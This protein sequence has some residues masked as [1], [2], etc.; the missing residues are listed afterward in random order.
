MDS[1]RFRAR[2]CMNMMGSQEGY[3]SGALISTVENGI[4]TVF[5]AVLITCVF[6]ETLS[7]WEDLD[8]DRFRLKIE[9]FGLETPRFRTFR[10]V[11]EAFRELL[12]PS[13]DVE[14]LLRDLGHRDLRPRLSQDLRL[15]RNQS[16]EPRGCDLLGRSGHSWP[17]FKVFKA[18]CDLRGHRK[19]CHRP[20]SRLARR[21]GLK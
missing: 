3:Y 5:G 13:T 16:R 21:V 12:R 11:F 20:L 4:Y 7:R 6:R 9:G 8:V 14:R 15:S 17:S 18:S 2:N 19:P 1:G 10:G